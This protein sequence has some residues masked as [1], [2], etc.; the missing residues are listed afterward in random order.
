MVERDKNRKFD[1]RCTVVVLLYNGQ[2]KAILI[3][4]RDL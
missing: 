4:Y 1:K 3:H 2:H